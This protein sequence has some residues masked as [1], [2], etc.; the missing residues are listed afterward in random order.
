MRRGLNG[1]GHRAEALVTGIGTRATSSVKPAQ[2]PRHQL[3]ALEWVDVGAPEREVVGQKTSGIAIASGAKSVTG[4]TAPATPEAQQWDGWGTALKPALE[5]ITVARKPFKGNV[6]ANVL[7]HGTGALNIDGAG[8]GS[9]R[10][11][12]RKPRGVAP[13]APMGGTR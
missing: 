13:R 6:A 9:L 10:Y 2:S 7:E 3:R 12:R 11:F 1:K 8:W 5:P 4:I